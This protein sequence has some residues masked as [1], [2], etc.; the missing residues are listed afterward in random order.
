MSG[1]EGSTSALTGDVSSSSGGSPTGDATASTG[2]D[3]ECGDGVVAGAEACDDGN[4]DDGDGCSATC[5][6]EDTRYVF[7]TLG[8]VNGNIGPIANADMR[9]QAEAEAHGLPG[10]YFA[11]LST[12]ETSPAKRFVVHELAYVLPGE[13]MPVVATGTDKLL[14]SGHMHA[15]NRGPDGVPFTVVETC[16]LGGLAWTGSQ[17]NGQ[18]HADTCMGFT[19]ADMGQVGRAGKLNGDGVGWSSGCSFDCSQSLRFYCVQQ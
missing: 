5:I 13:D 10:Q 1:A 17:N 11:W 18:P 7:A 2:A 14:S 9:C 4:E 19:N 15:I 16:D 6:R 3:V 8:L 12:A